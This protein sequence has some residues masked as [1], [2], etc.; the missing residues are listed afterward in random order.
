M[1]EGEP[2]EGGRAAEV[3]R[4]TYRELLADVSRF[5][6]VLKGLGLRKGDTVA[7]YMPMVPEV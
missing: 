5:A 2:T 1:Y 7:I 6:N 4:I 3:R